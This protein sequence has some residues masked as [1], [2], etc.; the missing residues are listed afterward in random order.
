MQSILKKVNS[1][2]LLL[3]ILFVFSLVL[4]LV[5]NTPAKAINFTTRSLSLSRNT[6]A[7]ATA[8]TIYTFSVAVPTGGNTG[9]RGVEVNFC[10]TPLT[11][12]CTAPT[13]MSVTSATIGTTS[14]V[15]GGTLTS[16]NAGTPNSALASS[17]T[18]AQLRFQWG[19]N[20]TLTLPQTVTFIFNSVQNPTTAGTFFAR[21]GFFGNNDT[22]YTTVTDSGTVAQSV[23]A[24]TNVS[25]K[26]QE[27][28]QVCAGAT[29]VDTN[30]AFGNGDTCNNSGVTGY[31]A[32][33][34]LGVADPALVRVTPVATGG[35]TQGNDTDGFVLLRTNANGGTTI[36]YR[37]IQDTSSGELKTVGASC[38]ANPSTVT[39]DRCINSA[40]QTQTS[41]AVSTITAGTEKFGMVIPFINRTGSSTTSVTADGNYAGDGA[42]GGTCN[43]ATG[44]NCWTWQYDG[45]ATTLATASG[46]TDD[47]LVLLRFA[48]T[49]SFSTPAAFFQANMD[50]FAVATY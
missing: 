43:N 27:I 9:L 6:N 35:T 17:G 40:A 2:Y 26:V 5:G 39:T 29:T 22:T 42:S 37:V 19:A 33:V 47:E 24:A 11:G 49:P 44:A 8:T 36:Q 10:T 48:A 21:I 20:Q 7:A 3:A 23:Q 41:S 50:I 15:S 32:A 13:G 38:N 25:F 16:S 1:Q 45:T 4:S 30:I 28:L 46:P 31:L 14:P 18:S 34:D 12:S